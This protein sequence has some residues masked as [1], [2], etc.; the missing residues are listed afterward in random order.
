[1]TWQPPE[2]LAWNYC[3]TCGAPLAWCWEGERERPYCSRC[4]RFF[5]DNPAPAS[6][7]IVR[8]AEGRILL[9][10]RAVE[11]CAGRWT[12][13]GGF[14]EPGETAE[15]C[16]ARELFEETGIR[17]GTVRLFGSAMGSN[18]LSGPVIVFGCAVLGW[19][20]T[21][22]PGSDAS[23]VA[24][25]APDALPEIPFDA[26]RRMLALCAALGVFPQLEI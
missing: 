6:C 12:L 1:M 21:P 4:R 17:A 19:S 5:Y 20:G 24:F 13:P 14:M 18:A 15:D 8:D 10:R 23:E 16:A 26:H 7:V 2:P 9:V 25:F 22:V 11:P 3:R